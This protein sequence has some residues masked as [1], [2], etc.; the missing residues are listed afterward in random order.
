MRVCRYWYMM[1]IGLVCYVLM[2]DVRSWCCLLIYDF[3]FYEFEGVV[4][5]YFLKWKDTSWSTTTPRTR[6]SDKSF[7]SL[8]LQLRRSFLHTDVIQKSEC[9]WLESGVCI[10][11]SVVGEHISYAHEWYI[12]LMNDASRERCEVDYGYIVSMR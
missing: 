9:M 11:L 6:Y 2:V 12:F 10:W 3:L 5:W 4:H 1:Y 7:S 8:S